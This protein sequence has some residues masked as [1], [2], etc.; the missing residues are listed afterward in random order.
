MEFMEKIE[1]L[2]ENFFVD[3]FA[4]EIW[5]D[6]YKA[7]NDKNIQ[8]TFKR[9]AY[10]IF[11]ND[12]EKAENLLIKLLERKISLGGRVVANVGL[13]G[14][15]VGFFNCYSIQR[16]KKPYDSLEGIYNDVLYA[17]KILKTEGGVGLDFSH[18]RPRGTFI[19][20]I[21]VST[22]GVVEYMRLFSKS[23]QLITQGDASDIVM[24][25]IE[26]M[27]K[28]NKIRKG[29]QIGLLRIEH[30]DIEEFITGKQSSNNGLE[31][32]NIS[33]VVTDKFMKAV[34][35]D[36]EWDLWFPN[37]HFEK[38]DDEWDGDFDKWLDKNYP[39]VIYKTV[40]AKELWN[41][42]LDSMY[43]RAE[44]GLIFIDNANKYNNLLPL[45]MKYVATNPCG[46]IVMSSDTYEYNGVTMMGDICNLGH[47]NLVSFYRK[48]TGFDWVEFE[49]CSALLVETL[50]RLIDISK[51]PFEELKNAAVMRRKLGCGVL[52]YGSLLMM[53][54]LP[55]GSTQANKFTKQILVNYLNNLYRASALL[56]KNKGTFP[57]YDD[58][59]YEEG[60]YIN[61]GYL[62][63]EVKE[64][65]KQYGLRNSALS[66]TAPTGNTGI[67]M[68]VVSGGVEP[69]FSLEYSRWANVTH[70]VQKELDGKYVYPKFWLGEFYETDDFKWTKQGDVDVLMSQ[71]GKYLIDDSRGLVK[72]VMC[73]DYG[74]R[75]CQDNLNEEEM[76][77]FIKRGVFRTA[78]E[79]S[80]GEHLFP[81]IIFSKVIDQ[82]VS[83][84][85]AKGT[86]F[87]TDKGIYRIEDLTDEK[88]MKP[89][90]F[91]K[92]NNDYYILDENGQ[93]Q[94]IKSVYYNGK[95][96]GI[97]LRFNNGYET[98]VSLVHKF[99]TPNGWVSASDLKKKDYVFYRTNELEN[100]VVDY[101]SFPIVHRPGNKFKDIKLPEYIDEKVAK[102]IGCFLADGYSSENSISIVEKSDEV[103]KVI[104]ELMY[105]MFG[106]ERIAVDKR[107]GVRSHM[108]HSRYIAEFFKEW[109]G[110]SAKDKRIPDEILRSPKSVQV[111][112]LEG[113]SLDGYISPTKY[114]NYLY[115]YEGY[116][117]NIVFGV[118]SILSQMGILYLISRRKVKNGKSSN[119]TYGIRCYPESHFIDTIE[120]HKNDYFVGI[121][122][123]YVYFSMD[124]LDMVLE[125]IG[126]GV[127]ESAKRR[128]IRNSLK[129]SSFLEYKKIKNLNLF[130]VVDINLIGMQVVDIEFVDDVDFYDIEVENT[131]SY[132]LNG[133]VSHNTVN[134][135]SNYDRSEFENLFFK[136]WKEGGKGITVYREGSMTAVL[137][138]TKSDA[139]VC[140]NTIEKVVSDAQ[141]KLAKVIKLVDN[142]DDSELDLLPNS[143]KQQVISLTDKVGISVLYKKELLDVEI[144]K[145]YL[146]LWKGIK[147]YIIVIHDDN[148]YPLEIF[149]QL[150]QE[151]G[152]NG[153]DIFRPELFL[154]R[155]C[156]WTSICRL[157]SLLLRYDVPLEDI[158][159]QL[160][161]SSYNITHLPGILVRILSNYP[162]VE[163]EGGVDESEVLID[164]ETDKQGQK[165]PLCGGMSLYK[166]EGC[167]KCFSCGYSRCG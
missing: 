82:T 159:K 125:R 135:P 42:I 73:V 35:N 152:Y 27:P 117:K 63:D 128:N 30:P 116:S 1:L 141:N 89:D 97:K 26:G 127:D 81:F 98:T 48:E 114:N 164:M 156:Y 37:I 23:A 104:T 79:L 59:V 16:T 115:I 51:Y 49:N 20:K 6:N 130:D 151:A 142:I 13:D 65:I 129:I 144:A 138:E 25:Y 131:H 139:S 4:E 85:V 94:K 154:E 21:G 107:N 93:K 88:N 118:S 46:E 140:D 102:F 113:L 100:N 166:I 45:G 31:F 143:F 33:V 12:E 69:V 61:N 7:N 66:T 76:N 9:I 3:E 136:F 64:I 165:C 43:N 34:E 95:G 39:I 147:V 10:T 109:L 54:G 22:P 71:D 99:K 101:V 72:K 60:G 90:T 84:C 14:L 56:A 80:V 83:K 8:D 123:K 57:L 2:S 120:E 145:R 149:A 91:V 15:D 86:L 75:W 150:P 74:Y 68:S 137:E 53:M 62:T 160:R 17:A 19:K 126:K 96:R 108:L 133:F 70:K 38:Y 41:K 5:N 78:L 55:Y 146:I 47:L 122:R 77:D 110:G 111:A 44:P 24:Q 112:F 163:E 103:S 132:L 52:G 28:K 161:K 162:L 153:D 148:G 87:T 32:F 58:S 106:E 40:K 119:I 157:T 18:I 121:K 158:M 29:A 50:D 134:L 105:Y 92:P 11:S 67:F 36:E 124:K 167:D 155:L